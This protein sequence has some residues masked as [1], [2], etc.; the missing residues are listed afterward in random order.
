MA[1][2]AWSLIDFDKPQWELRSKFDWLGLAALAA[3]LG[4][5]EY[6]LEEGPG[7]DWL[8][9]ESVAIL[10]AVMVVGGVVF[11]WRAL[12]RDE[13][14][15][16]LSA[17]GN[18]NFTLGSTFS[19]VMGIGL[20]G[21]TYL[22]PL[23]L[24][25]IRGYDS[26]MIGETVFVSG[27][28]MFLTAPI[29][30]M[31]SAKIDLRVMMLIGFLGFALSTWML[32]GMTAEWDFNELLI[33]QILRGMSLM[34]SMV[35]INNMAL[36]TLSPDKIKGASGLF[37]LTRN[38][39]GAVGLAVI[40]T[41][42]SDRREFHYARLSESVTW[43]NPEAVTQLKM[44]AANLTSRGLDGETA[45]LSQMSGRLQ[46]QAAVMSFIDIFVLLAFAFASLSI[47]AMMMKKPS[48]AK[49]AGGH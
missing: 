43:S 27:L 39:G 2:A 1:L 42:L 44:M 5:M 35:P 16:D 46:G 8:Q 30:G 34:I 9:D 6:V 22:Y 21:L 33:P 10:A 14:I 13:P 11:F 24:S 18:I 25:M 7:N 17:F 29:A 12:T 48:G 23:Y 38:L 32:T 45:A 19:F 28:A 20:Y 41:I 37:N 3:F 15:V 26:L 31:L 36:G 47:A 4:G 40:N 49:V